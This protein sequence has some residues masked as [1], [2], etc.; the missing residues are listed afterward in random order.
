MKKVSEY[1]TT[2]STQLNDQ[3][4]GREFTRWNRG[5]LLSYLN[6]GITELSGYKPEQFSADVT[7]TL[8]AGARQKAPDDAQRLVSVN[9]NADGTVVHEADIDLV[10]AFMPYTCCAVEVVFDAAGNPIY[11]A[12]TFSIDPKDPKI[13]YVS[14]D[15]PAGMTPTVKAT[16]IA[17]PTK[18]TLAAFDDLVNIEPKYEESIMDYMMGRAFD[19]DTESPMSRSNADKHLSRFYTAMGV[20]YKVESAFR[21]G[22]YG[23]TIGDGDPRA[24]I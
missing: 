3:R 13:F 10:K 6:G 22:N 1:V 20:K 12:R 8:A 7:L 18:Y 15:V 17:L 24:R 11:K 9:A 14:P 16:V 5:L 4:L 2:A 19:I 21:A 23:G